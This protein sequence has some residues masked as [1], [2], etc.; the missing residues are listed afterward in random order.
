MGHLTIACA[1]YSV[2]LD[3]TSVEE[4]E[5]APHSLR[6]LPD[7]PAEWPTYPTYAL[8]LTTQDGDTQRS[9]LNVLGY[10]VPSSVDDRAAVC[11][12]G[13]VVFLAGSFVVCVTPRLDKVIWAQDCD[14]GSCFG[15]YVLPGSH[16]LIVHSELAI[17]RL[18]GTGIVQWQAVGEDVF[19]G[20]FR[21]G[22][23]IIHATDFYGTVYSI[24][25]DTGEARVVRRSIPLE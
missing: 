12:Q 13:T 15:V 16:D 18:A 20:P 10:G 25:L 5:H 1:G 19:T 23:G 8:R 22:K 14:A 4:T 11:L 7:R 3:D 17:T 21:I 6:L 24:R 9:P 2:S